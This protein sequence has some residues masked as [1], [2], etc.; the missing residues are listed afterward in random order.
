[1][2]NGIGTSPAARPLRNALEQR[3][4]SPASDAAAMLTGYG[5]TDVILLVA[6]SPHCRS[7]AML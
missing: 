3:A 7:D 4:S 5:L 6:D 2:W 1:M